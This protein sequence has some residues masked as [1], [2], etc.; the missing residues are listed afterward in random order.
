MRCSARR[1]PTSVNSRRVFRV[2]GS[3]GSPP[4]DRC[5]TGTR[6][7]SSAPACSASRRSSCASSSLVPRVTRSPRPPRRNNRPAVT[8]RVA[9]AAALV[10]A[11]AASAAGATRF[12]PL[13]RFRV[14]AT[15]H[16]VIYFHQDD[17]RAAR[18]LAPIAEETWRGLQQPLGV[19]PPPRTH[20]V[21]ADQTELANAYATPVPYDTV[22]IYTAWPPGSEFDFDDW[23]RLAFTHEFT[24]I[25]PLDR[26]EGWARIA[27]GIFGRAPYVFPNL[28]LPRWQIE[29]I[30]TFEESALTGLGRLHA[31]EFR[32]IVGEAARAGRPEPLDRVNGGVTDWPGGLTPYAYGVGFHDYLAERFGVESLAALAAATARRF[33]YFSTRAFLYVYGETLGELWSDYQADTA[34]VANKTAAHTDGGI[35]RLTHAGFSTSGPRFDRFVCATCPARLLYSAANPHGFP[36]LNSVALDGSPPRQ[37]ATRYL[38]ATTAIGRDTIYFDQTETRRNVGLYSDLYGLSRGGGNVVEL[39]SNARLRDPDLS[40]DGMTLVATQARTGQRDLI[41]IPV[42]SG[43]SRAVTPLISEPDVYFDPPRWSPDG[44]SIAAERHR[45]GAMPEIVV[46]DA[47]TRAVRVVATDV[48]TRYVMPAWRP[49]GAA[50]VV[51]AAPE[52]ET[53]NLVEVAVDGSSMRQLTHTTGGALWPDVSPDRR[54]IAFAGYTVDGY[55][56]F[57]MPYPAANSVVGPPS[58]GGREVR[59]ETPDLN[60]FTSQ[61]Q[62]YSPLPTLVPTSWSPVIETD[63]EQLRVGAAVTGVDV[64]GYHTYAVDATWLTSSP[65][66]AIAPNGAVPDWHAYYAYDRWRPTWYAAASTSTSFFTGPPT[67]AG[68]PS[69]ATRR[70]R[71]IEAG[72]FLPFAHTRVSHVARASLLRS[73]LED[74]APTTT[75]TRAR[76]PIRFGWATLT[77]HIY[78][79]SVSREHGLRA[80]ATAEL[81]RRGLASSGD[82]TTATADA[83]AYLPGLAQHHVVALRLSGGVS[84]GD[85]AVGRTFL[86]G[87]SASDGGVLA[88]DS[89]SSSLLRG[90]PD[91][92]FA[93][94]RVALAN[95]EYRFPIARPQRGLGTW[96]LL[97]HT[98]HGAA[99][100]DAG[101]TWT[102]TFRSDAIKTSAGGE[103]SADVVLGYVTRVTITAGAAFGHD[104][105][106]LAS[107]R[108]TAYVRIGR[109]F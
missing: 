34:A 88:F 52:D 18:R 1:T 37:L 6:C 79:Y 98:L 38:G 41:T 8:R 108:A 56:I 4:D 42:V 87:G 75:V 109:A 10:L 67:A 53:F 48:R 49:D 45:L 57:T 106:A 81:V 80:G 39:T 94:N 22:V 77:D 99:F 92:S 28:F 72:V 20:V 101:E 71:T 21:L 29:G 91:A 107:D 64:L 78:G 105:S 33:P 55:D 97:L 63:A 47:Q 103:L 11:A 5:S 51:A 90:F 104:A 96:P 86:L 93:G 58:H 24:H 84:S 19:A 35:T 62:A 43:F 15:E 83:R 102:R 100:V 65:A 73:T 23:L 76:T 16:F 68:T 2:C 7:F 85:P 9:A 26:S 50:L 32:A 89:R 27:R 46:V 82:A 40:A 36:S 60:P 25:V 69:S 61:T 44:R 54:T 30:A 31:G 66:G 95:V 12:D 17:E 13:L 14:L 74:T 70:E 3:S 59:P